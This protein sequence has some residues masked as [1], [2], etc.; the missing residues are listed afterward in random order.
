M[1]GLKWTRKTTEKIA[2]EL[3]VGGLSVSANTV[4]RILKDLDFRLRSNEKKITRSKPVDRDAQFQNIEA[5]RK[6]FTSR[7]LPIISVDTKKKELIGPFKNAGREWAVQRR[8]VLDHDF[9]SDAEGIAVPYG[10]YLPTPNVGM[11]FVGTSHDTPEF[12]VDCI[13]GWWR[14][15]GRERYPAADRLL[16]LADSGGSNGASPRAWKYFLKHRFCDVHKLSITVAHYPSGASKWNPIE[17]RLFSEISKN[18]AAQP[19][20]SWETILKFIAT[21]STT[22]GLRVGSALVNKGYATGLRIKD[23]QMRALA[24]EV[25]AVLPKWNYTLRPS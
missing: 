10:I 9:R 16:I 2:A 8:P 19:L 6:S 4:G 1:S 18:W 14:L 13:E 24:V 5:L 11:V 15:D 3:K 23:A 20:D 12:A 25:D 17:H 22:T 7:G 21:T